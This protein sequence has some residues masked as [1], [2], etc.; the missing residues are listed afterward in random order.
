MTFRKNIV[1]LLR[2]NGKTNFIYN[3]NEHSKI[4]D[5]GCGNASTIIDIK[6]LKPGCKLTGIDIDDYNQTAESKKL[7]DNYVISQPKNFARAIE[8]IPGKFDVVMSTH[9]LEHTLDRKKVLINMLNKVKSNGLFYL[10]F[11]CM[12]SIKFPSRHGTLNYYDDNTHRDIPPSFDDVVRV[13]QEHNFKII[14]STRRH[15]PILLFLIGL[16]LEPFS[17]LK[18]KVL[19]GT[20]EFYGFETIIHAKKI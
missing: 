11:P 8:D 19:R 2:K 9:N 13:I 12:E 15:R 7:I 10:S 16:I 1:R 14:Y 18:K 17:V 20:W 5:V 6:A 4:L 3:L